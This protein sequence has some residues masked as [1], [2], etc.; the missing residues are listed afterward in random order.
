MENA[1]GVRQVQNDRIVRILN[2]VSV[3]GTYAERL[4]AALCLNSK[5]HNDFNRQMQSW[6]R[7][8]CAEVAEKMAD[9]LKATDP[10]GNRVALAQEIAT[11]IRL[12][13]SDERKA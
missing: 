4:L 9:K 7:E 2:D 13:T 8:R 5:S 1:E 11:L 12:R 10:D 3:G 6:E